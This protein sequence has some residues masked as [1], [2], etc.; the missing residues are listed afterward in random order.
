MSETHAKAATSSATT[1]PATGEVC[2]QSSSSSATATAGSA[3]GETPAEVA[4]SYATTEP[5][6]GEV[7]AHSTSSSVTA[8]SATG[9]TPA[10]V[11]TS[12]VTTEP[13]TGEV[14]AHSTSSSATA[15]TGSATVETPAEVASSSATTSGRLMSVL[16]YV[17]P[18]PKCK[19]VR[20]R[21]RKAD[22]AEVLTGSPFKQ[23]LLE[24]MANKKKSTIRPKSPARSVE[25]GSQQKK[26]VKK[27]KMT[28]R[29]DKKRGRKPKES[30]C[31][32]TATHPKVRRNE[33]TKKV[34]SS[35]SCIICGELYVNSRAGERWIQCEMCSGW[36]HED[37]TGGETSRGFF[38]DFCC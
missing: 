17:S 14:C 26:A 2:A 21:K 8:V 18:L 27:K 7:C 37:C 29:A 28:C 24:K 35:D 4:T 23:S 19:M 9:E 16:E 13:A 34:P 30:N 10:E 5:A 20:Q 6:T 11:A 38:C 3:T 33:P 1:E 36:C 12:S 25:S 31:T 22:R 32:K 15:T